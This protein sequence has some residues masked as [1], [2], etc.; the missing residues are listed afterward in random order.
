MKTYRLN[1]EKQNS[2]I[3]YV[4]DSLKN[5]IY[6]GSREHYGTT[7][8]SFYKDVN[9]TQVC[10][11][12]F[13]EEPK[14]YEHLDGYIVKCTNGR[15]NMLTDRF[16]LVDDTGFQSFDDEEW[17][18]TFNE[19]KNIYIFDNNG[20]YRFFDK[21]FVEIDTET[22]GESIIGYECKEIYIRD[23]RKSVYYLV[24]EN[25]SGDYNVMGPEGMLFYKYLPTIVCSDRH[26]NE[27]PIRFIMVKDSAANIAQYYDVMGEKVLQSKE[28]G[29]VWFTSLMLYS[30]DLNDGRDDYLF[31]KNMKDHYEI[32]VLTDDGAELEDYGLDDI[33][34][35]DN[36]D[37]LYVEKGGA[38]FLHTHE[39]NY[40]CYCAWKWN[41]NY[42]IIFRNGKY[43]LV[44]PKKY[45][46]LDWFDDIF[47]I[48][49]DFPI[50]KRDGKYNYLYDGGLLFSKWYD[51]AEDH[52]EKERECFFPVVENGVKKMLDWDENE[53]NEKGES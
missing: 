30:I 43:G 29:I 11:Y 46:V 3:E 37:V 20:E 31:A 47:S 38:T 25:S 32:Y 16:E 22:D 23:N 8:Y 45:D 2:G 49:S 10:D 28:S 51:F 50:V 33:K 41:D 34:V 1:E 13:L 6:I 14:L 48:R 26:I 17:I 35:D 18:I 36:E 12:E 7:L 5:G 52:I 24:L 4:G 19:E 40:L 21:D 15:W 27:Y 53:V 39:Y 9:D 44:D 42:Y